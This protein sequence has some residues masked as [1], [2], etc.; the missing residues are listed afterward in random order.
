MEV[1]KPEDPRYF[2]QT[3]D[4]LYDRH[5]YRITSETGDNTNVNSWQEVKEIWWNKK[6]VLSHV[7]VLDKEQKTKGFM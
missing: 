7:D 3:S 5:H 4:E 1:I 2:T 6:I